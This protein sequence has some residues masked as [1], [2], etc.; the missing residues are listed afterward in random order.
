MRPHIMNG[1]EELQNLLLNTKFLLVRGKSFEKL[2][3]KS[4]FAQLTYVE[5][6]DFTP[7]PKYEQV[8]KGVE[9]FRKEKCQ[10]IVAVGGGSAI[11]V[12]KCIKLFSTINTAEDYLIQQRVDSE[13]LLIAIP[14]TAGSGSEA[15]KHAVVYRNGEK[16]SISHE[17]MIPDYAILVPE[18]LEG[19]PIYQ[20]KCTLLDA[21]CQAIESWW[22]VNSTP[23]SISYSKEA[24]KEIKK[25][26][27]Q[28][29]EEN[30]ANSYRHIMKAAHLAGKAINITATT[31]AHAMSYKITS[32]YGI[33]HGH[34]VA[35]CMA[36]VWENITNNIAQCNDNR[37]GLYLQSVMTD[38]EMTFS[39]AEFKN[40]MEAF[41]MKELNVDIGEADYLELAKSVNISRLG[42][43]PISVQT[44]ELERMYRRILR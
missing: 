35:M 39:K 21:L 31:A 41:D 28:Y 2:A 11:D 24:I 23:E 17:S 29:I 30:S 33:P 15:T 27:K 12:A 1:T 38:I 16:Q 43:Y 36:E 10:A 37:G 32:L 3:I 25:Y 9:I 40:L 42:N 22:S 34:A 19:L 8:C 26:W 13:I 5:F 14:T 7:N 20:K 4:A 6:T 44:Q 18:V